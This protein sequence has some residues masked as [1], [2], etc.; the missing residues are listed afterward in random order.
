MKL[1]RFD[2]ET[3][4]LVAEKISAMVSKSYLEVGFVRTSLHYESSSMGHHVA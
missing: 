3:R 4:K 2:T 1:P